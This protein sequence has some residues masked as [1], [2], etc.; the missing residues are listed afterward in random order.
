MS[1][2][3]NIL[4]ISRI[5]LAIILLPIYVIKNETCYNISI[6]IIVIAMFTDIFDGYIA[7]KLNATSKK[8]YILDGLGDRAIHITLILIFFIRFQIN[9]S[10]VW[11][12][13]FREISIYALRIIFPEW[14][15]IKW[16]RMTS[17]IYVV[18]IRLWFVVYIIL[19]GLSNYNIKFY[20]QPVFVIQNVLVL[21]AI[22]VGYGGL[23]NY[24]SPL[25]NRKK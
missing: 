13:I 4:S 19:D 22:F 6:I 11:F 12:L 23:L 16:A 14:N 21:M 5:I 24:V 9:I 1:R 25:I 20:W 17:I 2:L 10:V 3:P 7:R 18:C 15:T 8:G